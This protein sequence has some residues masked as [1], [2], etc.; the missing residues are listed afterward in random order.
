MHDDLGAAAGSKDHF[1]MGWERGGR[2]TK[3]MS[4]ETFAKLAGNS[5]GVSFSLALFIEPQRRGI[6][7]LVTWS[8][9]SLIKFISFHSLFIF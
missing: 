8:F 3:A 1:D 5:P 9:L 2:V 7:G 4:M 6:G